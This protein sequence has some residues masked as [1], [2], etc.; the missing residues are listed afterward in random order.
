M[1]EASVKRSAAT[2]PGGGRDDDVLVPLEIISSVD[3]AEIQAVYLA[4]ARLDS[5]AVVTFVRA[6][7]AISQVGRLGWLKVGRVVLAGLL[8]AGL[9]HFQHTTRAA[10]THCFTAPP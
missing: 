10:A 8:R 4:S 5:D 3:A 2:A 9:F 7:A 1:S 6:L